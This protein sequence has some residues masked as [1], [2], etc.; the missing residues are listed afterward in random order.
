MG[1]T[2][3]AGDEGPRGNRQES[4]RPLFGRFNPRRRHAGLVTRLRQATF[5]L[6]IDAESLGIVA[7]HRA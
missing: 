1:C 6:G 5:K 2:A 4:P 7:D 3:G